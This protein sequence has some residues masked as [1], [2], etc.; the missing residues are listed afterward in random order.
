[1]T[2]QLGRP[3]EQLELGEE[4]RAFQLEVREWLAASAP[5][6]LRGVRLMRRQTG[7][8]RQALDAWADKL[9]EAGYMCVAW[10]TEYGG[11]GLG[12]V[13]VA[14]LNEE[15]HR[16]GVARI[17]R[18][19]GEQL[20][21]PSIIAHGTEE[22]KAYFLPRIISGE[23]RY[24][25]GFSEPDAGSDLASLRTRGVVDGDELVINGQKVWT[26]WFWDAT[27]FFCLCRTNESAPKH[28]G[29]SYVLIPLERDGSP[30]GVEFRP[31]KQMT[32]EGH[33]A[34]TFI[35]D[36][37][38]P[39]FNVIGGLDNGWHVAMTTLGNERGG[40]ATTQYTQFDDEFWRLV[41]EARRLGKLDD[42][43][44]RDELAWAFCNVEIM[45][46]SGLRLLG[47]LAAG[48]D[49]GA[50]GSASA[51]K[52]RWS[53]YERRLGELAL[54]LLGPESLVVGE[55]YKLGPWQQTFLQTRTHT[56]WGGTAEIQRNIIAERVLGLPKEPR[57]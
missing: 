51:N 34:E 19:M 18:G 15:F 12:G 57:Q 13:E 16:A 55:G 54:D 36:A 9:L 26:S 47:A 39:L 3:E 49:P 8:T 27:M 5:R 10:P 14:L 24:C 35:T 38:A 29:I 41:E 2:Q 52:I 43:L 20:V 50:G 11:R 1:V 17:T 32:G 21:G 37:R 28:A 42:P 7:E 56:I 40:N 53:E 23:D 4:A 31:I 44:V 22:Q 25:Q 45:R 33:F 6:E 30:N 48:R 46:Y